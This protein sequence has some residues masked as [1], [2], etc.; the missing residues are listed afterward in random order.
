MQSTAAE[1]KVQKSIGH[2]GPSAAAQVA[3][4]SLARTPLFLKKTAMAGTN[5][6]EKFDC[7]YYEVL[8]HV[9][10]SLA[11]GF[12]MMKGS[13]KGRYT[14]KVITIIRKDLHYG[15]HWRTQARFYE[16][17]N[18]PPQRTC[19]YMKTRNTLQMSKANPAVQC[20][21]ATSEVSHVRCKIKQ[22]HVKW[23]YGVLYIAER[24]TGNT[25]TT[26]GKKTH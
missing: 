8:H 23:R 3:N 14:N 2:T 25:A 11:T 21:S 9:R 19:I 22:V 5:M 16:F 1:Y 4:T 15:S 24:K 20:T 26:R 17:Q 12:T 13:S 10:M 18:N 6:K 7:R